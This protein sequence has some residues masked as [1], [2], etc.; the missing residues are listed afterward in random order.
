MRLTMISRERKR[1]MVL[2]MLVTFD[3]YEYPL[4]VTESLDELARKCNCSKNAISSAICHSR[5]NGGKS[6]FVKVE[7][8][9]D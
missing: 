6:R 4:I 3:K 2:Y 9:D 1:S 7:V 8:E 5:K